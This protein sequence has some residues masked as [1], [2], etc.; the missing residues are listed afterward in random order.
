VPR[1]WDV[2]ALVAVLVAALGLSLAFDSGW[3]LLFAVLILLI[4]GVGTGLL[5]RRSIAAGAPTTPIADRLTYAPLPALLAVAC[6]QLVH[7]LPLD[8]ILGA[9]L[10]PTV[11]MLSARALLLAAS[12]GLLYYCLAAQRDS[13]LLRPPPTSA[14]RFHLLTLVIVAAFVLFGAIYGTKDRTLV[15]GTGVGLVA[16]AL[17]LELYRTEPAETGRTWLLAGITGLIMAEM[18][19]ALNYLTLDAVRGGA[20]LILVFYVL[21]GLVQYAKAHALTRR[22]ALEYGGIG[23]IG[24]I[25]VLVSPAA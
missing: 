17:A 7:R 6:L 2:A 24:L 22:V 19:W 5:L 13:F 21:T 16:A 11:G 20:V 8:A 14:A 23:L 10:G 3:L 9:S 12:G 25:F 4:A 15:T 1:G 18:T